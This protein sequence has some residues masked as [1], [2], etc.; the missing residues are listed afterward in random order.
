MRL[1][2]HR[3]LKIIKLGGIQPYCL[4]KILDGTGKSLHVEPAEPPVVIGFGKIS[5]YPDRLC[6]ITGRLLV[7]TKVEFSQA[8]IMRMLRCSPVSGQCCIIIPDGPKVITEVIF[9]QPAVKVRFGIGGLEPIT[10]VKS[11]IAPW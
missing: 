5:L 3:G 1:L 11:L 2:R 4:V 8:H 10:F 7:F 9:C 6:K